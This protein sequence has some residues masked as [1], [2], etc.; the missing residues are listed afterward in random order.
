MGSFEISTAAA[1]SCSTVSTRCGHRSGGCACLCERGC[2]TS[3]LSCT[4]HR[5]A[6]RRAHAHKHTRTRLGLRLGLTPNSNRFNQAVPAHTDD[7][8]VFV[9]QVAA[10]GG[11]QPG[12]RAAAW[13]Q[14]RDQH[15]LPPQL[16]G[17]KHWRVYRPPLPLPYSHEQL[18]KDHA[19]PL[20]SEMLGDPILEARPPRPRTRAHSPA[21]RLSPLP[22]PQPPT[23]CLLPPASCACSRASCSTCR[24]ARR[25]KRV[26]T[27]VRAACTS[28]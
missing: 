19:S 3:S 25:T 5:A 11:L 1:P 9:L 14:P 27:R 16:A 20:T 8:D 24:E 4:S 15:V 22:S 23:S 26:P 13:L 28:R 6:R 17:C 7:Q 18:G 10:Y 2:T 21:A 12:R